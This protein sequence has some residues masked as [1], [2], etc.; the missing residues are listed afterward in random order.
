MYEN[1]KSLELNKAFNHAYVST[2]DDSTAR[3]RA[4]VRPLKEKNYGKRVARDESSCWTFGRFLRGSGTFL[5]ALP[6]F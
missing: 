5:E 2:N 3:M 1:P 4:L 6:L